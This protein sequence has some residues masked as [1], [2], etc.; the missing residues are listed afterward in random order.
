MYTL[1]AGRFLQALS[2][3]II[4]FHPVAV[5]VGSLSWNNQG[6]L[7]N[8]SPQRPAGEEPVFSNSPVYEGGYV[9]LGN[10]LRSIFC[11]STA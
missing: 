11:T 8:L 2:S 4:Y 6:T 3:S 9:M 1:C 5:H 10:V 7:G